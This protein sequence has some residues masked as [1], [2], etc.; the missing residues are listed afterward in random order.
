MTFPLVGARRATTPTGRAILA[1]AARAAD[2]GLADRIAATED[3]RK[4][5]LSSV[6][7]VTA[8]SATSADA[9]RAIARAGLASMRERMVFERDGEDLELSASL[10]RPRGRFESRKLAGDA[11][12]ATELEVPYRGQVLRGEALRRR[13]DAWVEGGIVEPSVATAVGRVI[14]QPG[15]L[16]LEGRRVV[17]VGAAAEMGPLAPLTAWGANVI[18]IDLPDDGVEQRIADVA[19]RGAGTVTVPV[20]DGA[21]GADLVRSLPELRRWLDEAAGRDALVLGMYAYADGGRHV[22]VTAAFD[23]LAREVM[24]ER[25]G[26]ALAFLATPTDAFVVPG[27]VIDAA[28]A[29]WE[30]RGARRLL[31]APLHAVSRGRLFAAAYAGGEPVADILVGQQGPNY[32]LAKR[33][34]RWQAIAAADGG[35]A[36][37]VNVAPPAWTRSVTKNRVLAA[38]YAGARRFGVE[39]FSPDTARVL[40]AAL[41]AHDLHQPPDPGRHPERLFSDGAAH[42]GLWRRAYEPRSVLGIAALT[43]LVRRQ[44]GVPR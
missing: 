24:R 14:D 28:R 3:W 4:G 27:E 15:W 22:R 5:Y 7:A 26:T 6:H 18:A 13:L 11:A 23:A 36:V 32:A 35:A 10:A 34:Q 44:R 25:P 30:R 31:Q 1:D 12:P 38:A 17:I 20:A 16:R 37:S 29:A 19:R 41:L 2:G 40:M 42:G 9:S 39:I 8:A 21:P 43:G 33:I